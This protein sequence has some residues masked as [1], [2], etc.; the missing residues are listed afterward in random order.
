MP[1]KIC[2]DGHLIMLL[3]LMTLFFLLVP[4]GASIF[5]VLHFITRA[6]CKQSYKAVKQT[7]KQHMNTP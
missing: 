7:Q 5:R 3:T 6:K 4:L 1:P 2:P